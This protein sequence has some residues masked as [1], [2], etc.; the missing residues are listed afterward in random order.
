MTCLA[1]VLVDK[2]H[3]YIY[4]HIRTITDWHLEYEKKRLIEI[5]YGI[6]KLFDT[7]DRMRRP[8]EI[9]NIVQTL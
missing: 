5:E 7:G 4:I 2:V 3:I 6:N 1:Q 9:E 8:V